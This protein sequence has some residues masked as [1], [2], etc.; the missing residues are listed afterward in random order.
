M[1]QT[2]SVQAKQH[3]A[4]LL[5]NIQSPPRLVTIYLVYL[6][7]DTP[8]HPRSQLPP[9][10]RGRAR[11]EVM[12]VLQVDASRTHAST[13]KYQVHARRRRVTASPCGPAR[14]AV[15][16]A[17]IVRPRGRVLSPPAALLHFAV[18]RGPASVCGGE[19]ERKPAA[20]PPPECSSVILVA[21]GLG[22]SVLSN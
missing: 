3:A 5:S 14:W 18:S 7:A 6:I 21:G 1:H 19:V 15:R 11:T 13:R 8:S 16:A 20:A 4:N 17:G 22:W 10:H 12:N 2:V 9:F